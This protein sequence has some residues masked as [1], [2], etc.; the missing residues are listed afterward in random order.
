MHTEAQ[1]R[2]K[3]NYQKKVKKILMQFYP[4]NKEDEELY[5]HIKAQPKINQYLKDLVRAD[6]QKKDN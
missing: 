1:K 3:N 4:S 2:A 6:M 5:A